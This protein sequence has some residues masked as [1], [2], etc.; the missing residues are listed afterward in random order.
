VKKLLSLRTAEQVALVDAVDRYWAS[1]ARGDEPD[2]LHS[3]PRTQR[4]ASK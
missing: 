1:V 3:R 2:S 4:A